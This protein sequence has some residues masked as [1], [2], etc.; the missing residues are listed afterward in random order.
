MRAF[1][2]RDL[3][4][5]SRIFREMLLVIGFS[6]A[7]YLLVRLAGGFHLLCNITENPAQV[8]LEEL[9][10]AALILN[11]FLL[12]FLLRRW[13]EAAEENA[14]LKLMDGT[15]KESERNF[16][17]VLENIDLIVVQMDSAASVVFCNDYLLRL[18]GRS[19]GETLGADWFELFVPAGRE[20]AREMFFQ[21]IHSGEIPGHFEDEIVTAGGERRLISWNNLPQRDSSGTINGLMSLGRDITEQRSFENSL[22]IYQDRLTALTS[23][24]AMAEERERR[25]IAGALHDQVAQTLAFAKMKL[26]ALGKSCCNGDCDH[27]C[28]SLGELID[29]SIREIRSLTIQL[30]P[31]A[32]YELGLEAA[33]QSLAERFAADHDLGVKF[34]DLGGE[35]PLSEEG[36]A[37]IYQSARESLINVVKHAGAK[38]VYIQVRRSSNLIHVEII[39]DGNG[40]DLGAVSGPDSLKLGFGL[41]NCRQ[42]LEQIG[43]RMMVTTSPGAGTTV[44]ITAPL[45]LADEGVD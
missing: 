31:P 35:K 16:R 34:L 15:L 4:S 22:M 2:W 38:V 25:R 6:I 14:R 36:R 21:N 42:R 44:A 24:L 7:V 27:F 13:R 40:F 30:C 33:L 19:R 10:G 8:Y 37:I 28:E 29:Q 45:Q 18:T 12:L 3:M 20:A 17:E 1:I 43:G 26:T 32:L 39:D 41:F 5:N 23:E 9:L 11:S